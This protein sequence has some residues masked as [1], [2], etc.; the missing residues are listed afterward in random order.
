MKKLLLAIFLVLFTATI[1]S[2]DWSVTVTWTRSPDTNL[3][4]EEVLLDDVNQCTVQELESTTCN[5]V[6]PFLNGEE[7]KV[8]STNSQGAFTDY[9]VGNLLSVPDPATGGIITITIIP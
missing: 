9:V 2:A 3:D 4:Y 7:V 6:I 5:F 1:A 8:R